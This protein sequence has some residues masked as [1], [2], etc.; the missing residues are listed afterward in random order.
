M[1]EHESA[2]GRVADVLRHHHGH[3][4]LHGA[5]GSD[6]FGQLAERIARFFGTPRYIMAQTMVVLLWLIYN[7]WVALHY[8]STKAFDPYPFI[9]LN[10]AFSTQAAYAAPLILLAQTR[11]AG[12][13]KAAEEAD[14]KH[15]EEIAQHSLAAQQSLADLIKENTRLTEEVRAIAAKARANTDRLD[16]IH[17][18][19]EAIGEKLGVVAGR[20]AADEYPPDG[21]RS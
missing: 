20:F 1:E 19:V 13:D 14:A 15:R 21:D 2:A 9:L 7:G 8:L 16:E 4:D 5:F 6:S 18:H 12:R 17:S 10:L 3:E 11:Q